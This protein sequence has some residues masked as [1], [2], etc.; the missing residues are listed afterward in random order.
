MANKLT[1][2]T[3]AFKAM[4]SICEL[5]FYL[6][7]QTE[8]DRIAK[9]AV[10][11]VA[12]F[13]EKYTRYKPTSITSKINGNAGK[14]KPV[15]VD[16]ET[17]ALLDYADRL[18][19]Q[20]DGLF[21]ITSGVLRKAWDFKSGQLPTKEV[22]EP[23]LELIAW[24]DV[25]RDNESIRLPKAG[26]QIDFGGFVKEYTADVVSS[27]CVD[28]GVV[29]G[30]IN[31]GG[32]I[33]VIGPHPDGLPWCVG[34][35]HPRVANTAIATVNIAS[36]AIAT[37]GDYERYMIVD[38]VRY[39]HLLNPKTGASLQPKLASVSIIAE[40][41]LLA[42]S[43]ST[44]S[45]LNSQKDKDYLQGIDLPYLQIDQSMNIAGTIKQT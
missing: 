23:L 10:K 9:L 8:M 36:G 6:P 35:Q 27:L 37:S 31:L 26:M 7:T 42:G 19:D 13:E 24:R 32:D 14:L 4:G 3:H 40:S 17:A 41:C 1:L 29:N 21:D 18:Y 5:K 43:F 34:I 38:G 39:C 11:E 20:S 2:Y 30:I 28:N 25:V 12:R 45:M 44:I 16:H 33:K 22:I 15:R